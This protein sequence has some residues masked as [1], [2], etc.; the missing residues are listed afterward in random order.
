M[1]KTFDFSGKWGI[2]VRNLYAAQSTQQVDELVILPEDTRIRAM[3]FG[4][5]WRTEGIQSFLYEVKLPLNYV[6]DYLNA[7]LPEYIDEA[8]L[9]RDEEDE[10]DNLLMTYGWPKDAKTLLQISNDKLHHLLLEFFAFD[11]LIHWYSDGPVSDHGVVINS[12]DQFYIK[13]DYLIIK[14]ECRKSGYPVKYQDV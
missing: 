11:M 1:G 2:E 3:N 5:H 6:I 8:I 9:Y 10:L 4:Q 12:H 13:N 7:Q 14:G